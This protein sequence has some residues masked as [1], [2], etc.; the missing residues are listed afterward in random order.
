MRHRKPIK[1]TKKDARIF[2]RT[3]AKI[4]KVNITPKISRG[5]TRF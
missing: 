2:T 4:K 1:N 5:G 3:A